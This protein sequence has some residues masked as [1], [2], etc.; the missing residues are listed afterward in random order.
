VPE[1]VVE[2][3]SPATRVN[4]LGVKRD[5][6]LDV[7]VCELWLADPAAKTLVRARRSSPDEELNSAD[8]LTSALLPGFSLALAQVFRAE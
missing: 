1:L 5:Y 3:L 7:G 8:T 4:D 6:Y 2:V